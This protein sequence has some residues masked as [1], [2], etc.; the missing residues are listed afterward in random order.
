MLGVC[1]FVSS[2]THVMRLVVEHVGKR[3]QVLAAVDGECTRAN[4]CNAPQVQLLWLW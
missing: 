4:E 2:A 3:H 1:A